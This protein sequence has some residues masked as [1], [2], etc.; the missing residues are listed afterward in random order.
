MRFSTLLA[1]SAVCLSVLP[2]PTLAE[3]PRSFSEIASELGETF[4]TIARDLGEL[5]IAD[6]SAHGHKTHHKARHHEIPAE[7]DSAA[8]V[9]VAEASAGLA[10]AE[11][12]T[13]PLP[14]SGVCRI[15]PA[16][17]EGPFY[18][19]RTKF[20]NNH[21]LTNGGR[22]K[23]KIISLIGT[24][25]DRRCNPISGAL[26]EIWQACSSGRYNHPNDPNP[27]PLDPNFRYWSRTITAADGKYNFTTVVP[28]DYPASEDWMRPSHVHF[29]VR[30]TGVAELT[31]QM[32][33]LNDQFNSQDRIL[34]AL[35]PADQNVVVVDVSSGTGNFRVTINK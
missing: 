25:V 26:V 24:I 7:I 2:T 30:N 3:E 28:G 1:F 6:V 11:A 21:D 32:Y 19:G 31:T 27:A 33:F 14:I 9:E 29:K 5:E 4:T 20:D 18:P 22:A 12:I 13:G 34:E 23:G 35:T 15:T 16:Q 10:Y 8:E 17:I